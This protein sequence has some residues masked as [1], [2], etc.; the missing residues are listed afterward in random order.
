[1]GWFPG[2]AINTVTGER[3]NI[4]FGE[5]S[6]YAQ[7][8]GADMLW[9]PTSNYVEGVDNYVFG[10]RHYIYVMNATR[11]PFY[12]FVTSALTTYATPSYDAGRWAIKMLGAAD[13]IMTLGRT[14]AEG[15]PFVCK[16]ITNAPTD[17]QH[18][19]VCD[20]LALLYASVAWVNMPLVNPANINNGTGNSWNPINIPC[21][22]TVEINVRT[23][24]GSYLSGNKTSSTAAGVAK[25]NYEMPAYQFIL[26]ASDAVLENLATRDGARQDYIDSLLGQITVI[27]NPYYSYSQYETSSQLETKVRIAN[28]PTGIENGVPKG[29]TIRIYTVDGTLVR[30]LGPTA[31]SRQVSEGHLA[32]STSVDWDLHN[33]TGIPIA[34]G[35]YLIHVSVPGIGERVI[36]WFGTMR[37]V[38]LNSFQF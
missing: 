17:Q 29:C 33:Q 23:P 14:P 5:D 2:Y 24:Y 31:V 32:E 22:A 16:G 38:D 21:D 9:N 1:M 8:N 15:V 7:F 6:R 3:L 28:L 25:V 12:N 30:T 36:K 10:G 18:V 13:H 27:P 37:P 11:H 20:S 35:M 34:G 4:M 19:T 26:N